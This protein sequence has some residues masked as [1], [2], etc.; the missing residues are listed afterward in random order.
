MRILLNPK[1][2]RLRNY[3]THIDEHFERDG[4]E[5]HNGRNV[6]RTL[7]VD[8]L[9]LCVKHYGL[10]SLRGRIA[11]KLYKPS[12]AEQAYVKPLLLRERGFES[13]EPVAYVKY[14]RGWLTTSTYFVCLHSDYRHSMSDV[15]G[16]SAAEREE[17]VRCFARFAARLHEDG[18]LHRD[19]SSGNILYDRREG[20][21]HF[22]L[23]DTNC[24]KCGR[25]VSIEKG[26]ANLASLDGD[27]TFFR[28]LAEAYARER[29]AD[30]ARCESL[31]LEARSANA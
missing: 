15:C 26:C 1:Y 18:F 16:L 22:A 14:R 29:G 7:R 21:L 24:M 3:L 11:N 8:D 6:V 27:E 9:T 17:V 13:P 31:I 19:F 10:P 28:Q 5:I 30:A 2:E 25:A 12:K 23:I 20:R 4:H